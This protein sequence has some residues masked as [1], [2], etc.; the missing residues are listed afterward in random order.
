MQWIDITC[1]LYRCAEHYPKVNLKP[2]VKVIG[3]ELIDSPVLANSLKAGWRVKLPDDSAGLFV[4]EVV[5]TRVMD[6]S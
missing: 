1:R 4:D 5:I 3:V 2:Y 6:T